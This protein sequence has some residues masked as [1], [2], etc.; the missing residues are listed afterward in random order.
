MGSL[1]EKERGGRMGEGETRQIKN[2]NRNIFD[3]PLK[4]V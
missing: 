4:R 3:I 2:T 1:A